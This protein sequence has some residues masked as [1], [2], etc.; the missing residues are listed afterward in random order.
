[1][2]SLEQ[3]KH[4][5]SKQLA[6]HTLRQWN[7]VRQNAT[8]DSK[9]RSPR[10]S[11]AE[12]TQKNQENRSE[13]GQTTPGGKKGMNGKKVLR[14]RDSSGGFCFVSPHRKWRGQPW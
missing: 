10:S 6:A 5:Y 3:R 4:Q 14:S 13:D 12:Y 7:A 1:M 8:S 9:D 2:S 11:S